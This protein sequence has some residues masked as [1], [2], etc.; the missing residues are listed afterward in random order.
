MF[1]QI[2]SF[3]RCDHHVFL[4]HCQEDRDTLVRPVYDRLMAAGVIPWLDQE[5]Y[6]YGRDSR[7]ALRD[8]VLRSRHVVFLVTDAL[9]TSARGWCVY[10][11]ALAEFAELNFRF[12]GGQFAHLFLP[13]Y[14]VSQEDVR[15]PRTVW[16]AARDRGRFYDHPADGSVVAWCAR[17]IQDF[18]TREQK[19]STELAGVARQ[20][21]AVAARLKLTPGLFDR[22]TKFHPKR[23]PRGVRGGAERAHDEVP[24]D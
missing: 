7:A 22:V 19:L 14:L 4:S 1:W 2:T 3:P 15:L 23:L 18:L 21:A 12:A 5:D 9:L 8:G 24:E 16:Q 11:L 17:E 10:E 20:D 13:L 6:Y